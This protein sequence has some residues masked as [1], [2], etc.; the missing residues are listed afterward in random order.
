MYCTKC[1]TRSSEGDVFCWKCGSR[2]SDTTPASPPIP[3]PISNPVNTPSPSLVCPR[4]DSANVQNYSLWKK[5]SDK[6]IGGIGAALGTGLGAGLGCLSGSAGC[7]IALLLLIFAPL[8]LLLVGLGFAT[9]FPIILVVIA[10]VVI[11]L[12]AYTIIRNR[13]S[14]DYICLKCQHIFKP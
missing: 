11:A 2:L 4:C 7:L 9:V 1:G 13:D 8:L 12:I 6:G 10:L 3:T 14:G 5:S